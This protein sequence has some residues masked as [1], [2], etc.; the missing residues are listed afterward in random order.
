MS[1]KWVENELRMSWKWVSNEWRMVSRRERASQWPIT[2]RVR[3]NCQSGTADALPTTVTD[4]RRGGQGPVGTAADT[5]WQWGGGERGPDVRCACRS[6]HDWMGA[7]VKRSVLWP[8]C[9]HPGPLARCPPMGRLHSPQRRP[10]AAHLS[11]LP[12]PWLFI[13]FCQQWEPP[14][15]LLASIAAQCRRV[16]WLELA[17]DVLSMRSVASHSIIWSLSHAAPLSSTP[18]HPH[19]PPG[20]RLSDPLSYSSISLAFQTYQHIIFYLF[21]D[22]FCVCVCVLMPLSFNWLNLTRIIQLVQ[23]DVQIKSQG[24]INRC[25]RVFST[26]RKKEDCFN[27]RSRLETWRGGT[28]IGTE[29]N[30]GKKIPLKRNPPLKEKYIHSHTYIYQYQYKYSIK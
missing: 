9:F 14:L 20:V 28:K 29:R 24:S 2:A 26:E 13:H 12:I 23:V 10:I 3:W 1:R 6:R 30:G 16:D 27:W 4:G 19:A 17:V 11:S 5:R 7:G 15:F 25:H 8:T 22:S 21:H 18:A